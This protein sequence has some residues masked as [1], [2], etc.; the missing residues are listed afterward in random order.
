MRKPERFQKMLDA[1]LADLRGRKGFADE[2]YPQAD[3][4]AR[5]ALKLRQLD[6]TELQQQGL[7]GKAMG[8][9]IRTARLDLIRQEKALAQPQQG[10]FSV[11]ESQ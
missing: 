10:Q 11:D 3:F 1:C 8:E 6:I 9:A 2:A 4:L 5:L 7:S